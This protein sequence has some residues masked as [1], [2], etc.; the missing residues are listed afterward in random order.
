[1]VEIILASTLSFRDRS[2]ITV[3]P[4]RR[5]WKI[6]SINLDVLE[7]NPLDSSIRNEIRF[8]I[9]D[10]VFFALAVCLL[11]IVFFFF[12]EDLISPVN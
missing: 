8:L 9:A 1:M 2:I 10:I 6:S 5:C 4:V 7:C 12:D 11:Y 3:F